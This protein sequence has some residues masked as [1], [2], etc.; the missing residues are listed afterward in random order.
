M[1]KRAYVYYVLHSIP[2]DEL[3]TPLK[4]KCCYITDSKFGRSE[5]DELDDRK[6]SERDSKYLISEI[7]LYH[8]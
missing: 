4:V 5:Y 7:S 8:F 2:H 6:Y 3:Y 1:P